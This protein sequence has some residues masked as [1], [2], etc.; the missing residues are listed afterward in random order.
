MEDKDVLLEEIAE[1]GRKQVWL[2]RMQCLMMV[3]CAVCCVAVLVM[4]LEFLPQV[5]AVIDQMETV[6]SNLERTTEDLAAMD[7][8]KMVEDVD[9]LVVTGQES[10]EKTMEKL[11]SIDF[12][13]LNEAISD[14]KA[15]IEPLAKLFKAF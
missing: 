8:Q 13:A 10:L 6:L 15:V 11:E 1:N 9:E 14:L 12:D 7:L 4:I 2:Q 3:V 5:S